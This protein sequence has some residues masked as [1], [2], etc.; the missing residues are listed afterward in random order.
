[1]QTVKPMRGDWIAAAACRYEDGRHRHPCAGQYLQRTA[2]AGIR[3]MGPA[4]REK[5]CNR[6]SG[7]HQ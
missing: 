5:G 4:E 2:G 7:S 3:C 6:L 1:M